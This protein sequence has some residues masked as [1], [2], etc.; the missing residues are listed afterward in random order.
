MG[1]L[2]VTRPSA[3]HNGLSGSTLWKFLVCE[4]SEDPPRTRTKGVAGHTMIE[5]N[6]PECTTSVLTAL[7]IFREHH[8]K[9]RA[10]DIE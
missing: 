3:D 10:A 5:R 9:Y 6:Y 7:A 2:R 4:R 1:D 8:P